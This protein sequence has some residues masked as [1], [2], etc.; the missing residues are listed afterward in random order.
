ME[1][2]KTEIR[3]LVELPEIPLYRM[4]K[5]SATECAVVL[6]LCSRLELV[7]EVKHSKGRELLLHIVAMLTKMT[8]PKE[9]VLP[10]ATARW[11]SPRYTNS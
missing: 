1:A 5:R 2:V 8:P 11:Q 7:E 10:L 6:D 9:L 4:A 3:Q